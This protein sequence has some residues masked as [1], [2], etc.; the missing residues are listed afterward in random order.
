MLFTEKDKVAI[1][2]LRKNE[3]YGAK[4]FQKE[5]PTI[6]LSLSG[7]NRILKKIDERCYRY[8]ERTKGAGQPQS[9]HCDNNTERIEQLYARVKVNGGHFEHKLNQ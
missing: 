4:R 9:V 6:Q 3:R 2:F 5:F 7:L 1:E 8:I